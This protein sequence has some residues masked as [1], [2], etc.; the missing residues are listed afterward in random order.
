MLCYSGE[1]TEILVPLTKEAIRTAQLHTYEGSFKDPE[2]L[3]HWSGSGNLRSTSA[4]LTSPAY[5]VA[6]VH[7]WNACFVQDHG[8]S[9]RQT[10]VPFEPKDGSAIK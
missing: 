4:N 10:A 9:P 2:V 8:H 3:K 6:A 7:S 5:S 1:P